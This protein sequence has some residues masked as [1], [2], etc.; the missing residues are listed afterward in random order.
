MADTGDAMTKFIPD[1]LMNH[2]LP[3]NWDVTKVW[4]LGTPVDEVPVSDLEYLL[5]LPLWSSVQGKGMLF[6]LAPIS[7]ITDRTISPWQTERLQSADTTY[8]LDLLLYQGKSW[9]LDGVHRFAR[10]YSEGKDTVRARFH[11]ESCVPNII[12]GQQAAQ[13]DALTGAP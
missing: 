5:H 4:A 11:P 6:D 9:I 1:Q 13:R 8:A 7:V 2:I 10:L 3:F 12:V